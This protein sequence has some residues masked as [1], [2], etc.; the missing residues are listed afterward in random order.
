[1]QIVKDRG[2]SKTVESKRNVFDNLKK[3]HPIV[4]LLSHYACRIEAEK[5]SVM[6][7]GKVYSMN[8][9]QFSYNNENHDSA[10]EN[11]RRTPVVLLTILLCATLGVACFFGGRATA[12]NRGEESGGDVKSEQS[13]DTQ[14]RET[15]KEDAVSASSSAEND[16]HLSTSSS[17]ETYSAKEVAKMTV[18]SVVEIQTEAVVTGSFMRQY[19]TSGSGSGVIISE[20]GYIVTNHHVID[21]ATNITVR[22]RNGEEY[23]AKLIG[24]DEQADIAVLKIE[25]KDL[26]PATIGKSSVLEVGDEVLAIGNPLGELGGTVTSGIISALQREIYI[27]NQKMTLLQTNAAIN[28]GNSG[29]GLF[30]AAGELIGIVNAK[31]MAEGIEGIGFAIPIDTAVP[32]IEDLMQYGYVRGR[33]NF[34]VT[35]VDI[36]SSS[37]AMYYGVSQYGTYVYSVEEGSDAETAGLRSG[38]IITAINGISISSQDAVTAILDESKVGDTLVI[39]VTRVTKEGS[40][41]RTSVS[42]EELEIRLTLTEYVPAYVNTDADHGSVAA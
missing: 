3:L 6:E 36:Y 30:N 26:Q 21:E 23:E 13:A 7:K 5:R 28:P 20:D 15:E 16:Y 10:K 1:M 33:V 35:F 25:A 17:G 2:L 19:V 4:K 39:S 22:L 31:T 40:G 37:Y 34:G 9:N 12:F 27:E 42:T 18:D 11:M 29:G 24:S 41:Y 32:V 38:D 14:D 8:Q